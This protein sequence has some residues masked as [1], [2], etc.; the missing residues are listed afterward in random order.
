MKHSVEDAANRWCK[1]RG[2]VGALLGLGLV[3][4][5]ALPAVA[6]SSG[7]SGSW[8][9]HGTMVFP[10]GDR[11]RAQC[12]VRYTQT[13]VTRYKATA[14]CATS[15]ARVEQTATLRRVSDSHY[16]GTFY[17]S[18]YGV[19]GSISV[20]MRGR[21]QSVSLSGDNGARASLRL[22]R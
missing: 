5:S 17:N 9:G 18:E 16:V 3:A 8:S 2:M 6:Q 13:S 19:S 10:S 4:A 7:L 12:R 15:S 20:Q 14:V 21:E 1:A 11:E 22:T